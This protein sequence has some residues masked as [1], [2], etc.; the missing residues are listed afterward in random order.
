MSHGGKILVAQRQTTN[1]RF[2]IGYF[3]SMVKTSGVL[4][5]NHALIIFIEVIGAAF[6]GEAVEFADFLVDGPQADAFFPDN[7]K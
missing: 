4:K 5:A 1:N 6:G 3:D 2:E 7:I